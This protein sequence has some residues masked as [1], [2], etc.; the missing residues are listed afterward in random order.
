VLAGSPFRDPAK[1]RSSV[2]KETTDTVSLVGNSLW[3]GGG[4]EKSEL[5]PVNDSIF[6]TRDYV[7]K[8]G[9]VWRNGKVTDYFYE[10]PDGQRLVFAKVQPK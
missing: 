3:I 8:T 2:D 5:I 4:T 1:F 6:F 9:F 7:G 10:F